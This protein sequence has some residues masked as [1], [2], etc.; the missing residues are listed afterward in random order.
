MNLLFFSKEQVVKCSLL[1][2]QV[3]NVFL[4]GHSNPE[5]KLIGLK[6]TQVFKHIDVPDF[7]LGPLRYSSISTWT[8]L[9]GSPFRFLFCVL[10]PQK[11]RIVLTRSVLFYA[12]LCVLNVFNGNRSYLQRSNCNV[13]AGKQTLETGIPSGIWPFSVNISYYN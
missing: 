6:M 8:S 5:L 1:V 10:L 7:L 11:G 12:F 13:Y 9:Y 4:D 3:T 2:L